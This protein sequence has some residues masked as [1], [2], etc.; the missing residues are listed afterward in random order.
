LVNLC[1][2]LAHAVQCD[3]AILT[4]RSPALADA[5]WRAVIAH[6]AETATRRRPHRPPPR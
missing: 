6:R 3:S 1:E 2:E 4:R 5:A